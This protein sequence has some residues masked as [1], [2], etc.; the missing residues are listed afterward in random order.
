MCGCVDVVWCWLLDV[1][2][3]NIVYVSRCHFVEERGRSTVETM[4]VNDIGCQ[5]ERE[6]KTVWQ[7]VSVET[8][9]SDDH[10]NHEFTD[11]SEIKRQCRCSML[12]VVVNHKSK[13]CYNQVTKL[14]LDGVVEVVSSQRDDSGSSRV[15]IKFDLAVVIDGC[16]CRCWS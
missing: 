9:W 1:G 8:L 3:D 7:C 14:I 2:S 16:W 15:Q 11:W 10:D 6:C 12:Y 4:L 13:W 5:S